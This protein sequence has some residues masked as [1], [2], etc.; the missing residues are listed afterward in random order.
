MARWGNKR[1]G[2]TLRTQRLKLA[3]LLALPF[4]LVSNPTLHPL[5]AGAI[6]SVMGLL[7][8]G[9]A[10]GCILKDQ[11]LSTGGPYGLVRHPLYLGSFLVGLGLAT[12]GGRWWLIPLYLGL[13]VLLY[14]GT[15]VKEEEEL[16]RLFGEGYEAY[17]RRVPAFLPRLRGGATISAPPVFCLSLYFRNKEWEAALGTVMAYGLLWLKMSLM[18]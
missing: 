17:R 1:K 18:G 2:L 15:V 14:R 5:L 8:R 11:V 16:A 13:F 10:A 3:W 12:A 6:L 7:V 4:L 9:A